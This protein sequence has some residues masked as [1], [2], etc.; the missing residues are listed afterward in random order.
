MTE[1]REKKKLYEKYLFLFIGFFRTQFGGAIAGTEAVG[2]VGAVGRWAKHHRQLHLVGS[3][4][5][6]A[7]GAGHCIAG[8]YV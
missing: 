2:A 1:G 5:A 6:H 3:L 4:A 7:G 8:G